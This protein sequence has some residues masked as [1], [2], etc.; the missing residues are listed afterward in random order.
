VF[1]VKVTLPDKYPDQ[2]PFLAFKDKIYHL[3]VDPITGQVSM[4]ILKDDWSPFLTL[5]AVFDSLDS[6]LEEPEVDYAATEGLRSEYMND[7][8]KYAKKVS[9]MVNLIASEAKE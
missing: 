6:I 3:N 2:P 4:P 7:P 8:D 1:N 9:Q 5:S